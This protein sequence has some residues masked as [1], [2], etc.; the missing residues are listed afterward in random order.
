MLISSW[1]ECLRIY[2]NLAPAV[3]EPE[4]SSLEIQCSMFYEHFDALHAREA[5]SFSNAGARSLREENHSFPATN[6]S[7]KVSNQK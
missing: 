6:A 1:V 4:S 3:E 7:S 2:S 5:E